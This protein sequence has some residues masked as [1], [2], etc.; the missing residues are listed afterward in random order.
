MRS[1]ATT[2]LALSLLLACVGLSEREKAEMDELVGT[3][4]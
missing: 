3:L 1:L 2:S 4:T